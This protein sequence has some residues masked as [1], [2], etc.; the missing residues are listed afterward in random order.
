MPRNRNL[1]PRLEYLFGETGSG[2]LVW[3]T[4][5][6]APVDDV[7]IFVFSVNEKTAMRIG[8]NPFGYRSFHGDRFLRLVG[9]TGSVMC[10]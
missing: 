10:K 9:N 1:I 5:F 7:A 3:I 8:L 6:G 2:L 4:E